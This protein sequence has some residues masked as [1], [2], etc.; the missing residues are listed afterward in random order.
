M[1]V[2]QKLVEILSGISIPFTAQIGKGLY[3]GHFGGIIIGGEIVMG[4][5][6]NLSQGV[7]IG[8]AGRGGKQLSPII[9][10]RVYIGPGA[11]VFGGIRIGNDVAIGANAVVSDDVPDNGVVVGVP[12]KII[13]YTSSKDFVLFNTKMTNLL[14][15]TKI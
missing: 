14:D 13:S 12:G 2:F 9:G 6:C 8:Q 10:N 5:F 15:Q 4:D 7:T 11:K 3:I 1:T